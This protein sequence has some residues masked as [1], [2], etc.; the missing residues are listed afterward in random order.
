MKKLLYIIIVILVYGCH[1]SHSNLGDS[2]VYDSRCIYKNGDKWLIPDQVLN[3]EYDKNYIIAYQK[4]DSAYFRE[5]YID[6]YK[7]IPDSTLWPSLEETDSL[8]ALLDSMLE[9][10]DCYWIIRKADCK[11]YGPMT[12]TDFYRECRKMKIT[13]MMDKKYEQPFLKSK[14]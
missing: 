13:I 3:Y 12:E 14:E 4:P 10:K 11:L 1:D 6:Y 7:S 5:F 9:I 8:E 2:Y